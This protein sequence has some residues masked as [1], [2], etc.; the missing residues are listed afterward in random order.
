MLEEYLMAT[1]SN[2]QIVI[3]PPNFQQV[4]LKVTGLTPLIQNK[5]KETIIQQM[6]DAR[7]GKAKSYWLDSINPKQNERNHHP[8]DGRRS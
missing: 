6:E 3:N 2:V 8:A 5:M 1:K 7:K 4:K